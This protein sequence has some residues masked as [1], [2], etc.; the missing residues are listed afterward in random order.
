MENQ[1]TKIGIDRALTKFTDR[2]TRIFHATITHTHTAQR[3]I[4]QE[5][6]KTI[7]SGC[8][9]MFR[10]SSL[11]YLLLCVIPLAFFTIIFNLTC[12]VAVC[13]VMLWWGDTS[14]QPRQY[15]SENATEKRPQLWIDLT[16]IIHGQQKQNREQWASI[17][18]FA[19]P[20]GIG[21]FSKHLLHPSVPQ[22]RNTPPPASSESDYGAP[23]SAFLLPIPRPTM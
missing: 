20:D 15:V 23:V 22:N 17:A 6:S 4:A 3:Y 14:M 7:N 18:I 5:S 16:N 19:P 9:C 13:M 1:C 10:R 11:V 21:I 2:I 8:F 12:I